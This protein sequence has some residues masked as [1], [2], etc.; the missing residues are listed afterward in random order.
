MMVVLEPKEQ[1]AVLLDHAGEVRV[2]AHLQV[3][4]YLRSGI[5]MIRMVSLCTSEDNKDWQF[6]LQKSNAVKIFPRKNCF[7]GRASWFS[8]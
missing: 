5:E 8:F 6:P 2:L 7:Q 1:L 4:M 3:R